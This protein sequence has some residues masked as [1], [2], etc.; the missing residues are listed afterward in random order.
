MDRVHGL[1]KKT[2]VR[3]QFADFAYK[4]KKSAKIPFGLETTTAPLLEEILAEDSSLA[5]SVAGLM[6][7]AKVPGTIVSYESATNPDFSE[8]SILHYVAQQDKDNCSLAALSQIKPALT[9]VESLSTLHSA[10]STATASLGR[11]T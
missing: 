1:T 9:L 6:A 4:P 8:K 7:Q 10:D 3:N 2:T 5:D 11:W